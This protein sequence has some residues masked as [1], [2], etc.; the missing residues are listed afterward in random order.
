LYLEGN[1]LEPQWKEVAAAKQA[2]F[3]GVYRLNGCGDGFNA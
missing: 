2:M 3:S 1:A